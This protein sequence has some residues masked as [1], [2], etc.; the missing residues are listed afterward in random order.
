MSNTNQE[1]ALDEVSK[2]FQ[3]HLNVENNFRIIFS[4]KYGT[5]KSFFLNRYFDARK[6]KYNKFLISPVNYVVSSNDDIFELIKVDIIKQL[7]FDGYVQK[8]PTKEKSKVVQALQFLHDN[9]TIPI[10]HIVSM[11]SKVNPYLTITDG[12]LS[13]IE[14]LVKEY[15]AYEKKLNST[16][17]LNSEHLEQFVEDFTKRTGSIFEDDFITQTINSELEDIRKGGK[18]ENVLI[19]DDLDRIDPEHIFRILNI[20]S[21]HNNHW[22][23]ENKF[24][25]DRIVIVC[26]IDN[27]KKTFYH[28]YGNDVDFSGYI[29]KFYSTDIFFFTNSDAIETYI[30]GNS[31]LNF[32][33]G[34]KKLLNL[35]LTFFLEEEKITLRKIIKSHFKMDFYEGINI[36]N[37]VDYSYGLPMPF[38]DSKTDVSIQT[39]N[40][41]IFKIIKLLS[42]IWGDYYDFKDSLTQESNYILNLNSDSADDIMKFLVIPFHITREHDGNSLYYDQVASNRVEYPKCQLLGLNYRIN[43]NWSN[44]KK[45]TAGQDYFLNSKAVFLSYS[46]AYNRLDA[47]VT[48]SEIF[49]SFLDI[50]TVFEE[51]KMLSELGL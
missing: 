1:V 3:A 8:I 39:K 21:A 29:D 19:I 46:G 40:M 31:M 34:G 11:F 38:F 2:K 47:H 49:N 13:G 14:K 4:G 25:F 33:T 16:L 26:D 37:R 48:Y 7:F 20:L 17:S 42:V 45:Y 36:T 22:D 32:S 43:L 35:I 15:E 27:I 18:K 5:G 28:R 41:E 50:I 23:K 12:M 6:E 10:K 9:P 51:R 30:E 24:K 44:T